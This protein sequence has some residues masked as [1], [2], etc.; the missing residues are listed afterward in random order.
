MEKSWQF[1]MCFLLYFYTCTLLVGASPNQTTHL[2]V[3]I[4]E[5]LPVGSHVVNVTTGSE[6]EIAAGDEYNRFEITNGV[7]LVANPLDRQ[8][9]SF[10]RLLVF[11]FGAAGE[12]DSTF[13]VTIIIRDVPGYPPVY[14]STCE[15]TAW[16]PENVT[17]LVNL[18]D[19]SEVNITHYGEVVIQTNPTDRNIPFYG[20]Y[21]L[22]TDRFLFDTDN[23]MCEMGLTLAI[24]SNSDKDLV[25]ILYNNGVRKM[26][27]PN[28]ETGANLDFFIY[29]NGQP[30]PGFDTTRPLLTEQDFA[31]N[32]VTRTWMKGELYDLLVY[33]H[34]NLLKTGTDMTFQCHTAVYLPS[35]LPPTGGNMTF[36]M[37]FEL[38]GCGEGK[39]GGKCDKD[40]VCKNGARC[41][42]FNGACLCAPGWKG[43]AC[44]IPTPAVVL[45]A[46]PARNVYVGEN[47]TLV[48]KS[49]HV[50]NISAMVMKFRSF[51][52]NQT[53]VLVNVSANVTEY[54]VTVNSHSSGVYSCT[55]FTDSGSQ[56]EQDYLLIVT[57]RP[58]VISRSQQMLTS[59]SKSLYAL[60]GLIPL[61]VIIGI[62]LVRRGLLQKVVKLCDCL[63]N[64]QRQEDEAAIPLQQALANPECPDRKTASRLA[65][66]ELKNEDLTIQKLIGQGRFGHVVLGRLN[67]RE[68]GQVTVVAKS[69]NVDRLE[70]G[71]GCQWNR[72]FYREADILI[73]LH[74]HAEVLNDGERRVHP[75]IIQLYGV[76][77]SSEPK[78]IVLEYVPRGDL[79]EYLRQCRAPDSAVTLQDLLQLAIGVTRALQELELL[80]IVHRDVAARN[81]LVGEDIVAKLADFGLARDVYTD[82]T[83][84]HEKAGGR[85]EP[86]PLKWMSLES[87]RDG[88]Y[89]CWSDVWSFGVLLWEIATRGEEPHYSDVAR[90]SCRH[91]VWILKEGGRLERPGGCPVELY[92][93]MSKCWNAIPSH[94][95]TPEVLEQKLRGLT[96]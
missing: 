36:S 11:V 83:Y 45:Y 51:L 19:F 68:R 49:V 24:I 26:R 84:V 47:V 93:L 74:E 69:A 67:V 50:H 95:P 75:N 48:C 10:Y 34:V 42:G 17:R 60:F 57:E 55:V 71:R 1:Q 18:T 58:T 63:H 38:L 44:D 40:C 66:W 52:T 39:Y 3:A 90:P 94:R 86:L 64:L 87:L 92:R 88:E 9:Q 59:N 8:I 25:R 33:L 70:E 4:D 12:L 73:A 31:H 37:S 20:Q 62:A 76:I 43:V 30:I 27:C 32:A 56:H 46:T 2:T 14:N 15:T 21:M 7:I 41:H 35:L 29:K 61:L 80:K 65:R 28:K 54:D 78:R 6:Y 81:V 85:D 22:Y 91:L 5:N 79:R 13:N 23:D 96:D 72:D 82:A 16:Q 77:T 89:T 53:T